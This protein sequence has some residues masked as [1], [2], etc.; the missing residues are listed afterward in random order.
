[1]M[2]LPTPM[3]LLPKPAGALES[4]SN[5]GYYFEEDEEVGT[6]IHQMERAKLIDDRRCFDFVKPILLAHPV[7]S[8]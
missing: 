5:E 8:K 7:S 3:A 4:F 1:M 2:V 6:L